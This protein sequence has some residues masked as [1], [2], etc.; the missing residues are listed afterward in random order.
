MHLTAKVMM[1][2]LALI[3]VIGDRSRFR[4]CLDLS[5]GEQSG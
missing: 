4:R 1:T 3:A 2:R 5:G